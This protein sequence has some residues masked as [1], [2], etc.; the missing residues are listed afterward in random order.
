MFSKHLL[1]AKWSHAPGKH[2]SL[3]QTKC[4]LIMEFALSQNEQAT[5]NEYVNYKLH[6]VMKLEGYK[7]YERKSNGRTRQHRV[8]RKTIEMV[9]EVRC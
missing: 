9:S 1:C 6:I 4:L 3:E 2:P 5:E 7:Y 8:G